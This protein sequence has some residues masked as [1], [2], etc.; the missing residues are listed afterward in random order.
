M[1]KNFTIDI[2]R[3]K[4]YPDLSCY[5]MNIAQMAARAVEDGA[6]EEL[7]PSWSKFASDPLKGKGFFTYMLQALFE[8]KHDSLEMDVE[9]QVGEIA[10]R[11]VAM[12]FIASAN[13]DN[14]MKTAQIA[15]RALVGYT[16]ITLCGHKD[17][18]I[19]GQRV[20]NRNSQQ[21]VK[22]VLDQDDANILILSNQMAAR[23]F[24][25]PEITELYLSYDNGDNGATIQKMSRTL[26][27][28]KSANKVGRVF[29]LSFDPNRDDKFDSMVMEA[30]LKV[31]KSDEDI[32][33]AMRRVLQSVDIFRCSEDGAE[34]FAEAEFIRS[35]MARDGLSRVMGKIA[36]VSSI[37][38]E[39]VA[40]LASGNIDVA[41]MTK[42]MASS[43]GKTYAEKADK[44]KGVKRDLSAEKLLAKAREMITTIIEN[45]D[46]IIY[47]T[48]Q[49]NVQKALESVEAQGLESAVT[50]RFGVDYDLIKFV[51][52]TG[53]IKQ[54]WVDM[55]M[56][57]EQV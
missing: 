24:S 21:L 51:F 36:D 43:M 39:V 52:D 42:I 46:I 47:G 7:L 25:I 2:G 17:N 8:G 26:T 20:T 5:Q 12:M 14:L 40:G 50:D 4:L 6:D 38:D 48:D 29:S 13:N 16:V 22:E 31:K 3:D 19:N 44:K 41:R 57:A 49:T 15:D 55:R 28:S 9:Y 23:S 56:S 32:V 1:L 54:D 30:A 10:Q 35:A 33:S 53:I 37:P 27:P 11:R 45:M 34:L 18:R